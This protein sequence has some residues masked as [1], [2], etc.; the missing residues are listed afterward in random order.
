M[1]KSE[2]Q[3]FLYTI[4]GLVV[5]LVVF[6]G[7]IIAFSLKSQQAD[8]EVIEEGQ[9][10]K[11]DYD[12]RPFLDA[13]WSFS[14]YSE[15][16]TVGSGSHQEEI[17]P[18]IIYFK[19]Y[20][21]DVD[22]NRPIAEKYYQEAEWIHPGEEISFKHTFYDY[23]FDKGK[24]LA[25]LRVEL[26]IT[27]NNETDIVYDSVDFNLEVRGSATPSEI[28][29]IIIPTI[30]IGSILLVTYLLQNRLNKKMYETITFYNA[31]YF[32]F[33]F[34]KRKQQ[35]KKAANIQKPSN[36]LFFE[37]DFTATWEGSL[38]PSEFEKRYFP[39]MDGEPLDGS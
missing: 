22:N 16:K 32:I 15:A 12:P 36:D 31:W 30:G 8:F 25:K 23:L 3:N 21:Q 35:N 9:Y 27:K 33:K 19:F 34:F 18:F 17:Y 10:I 14:F 7:L 1:S 2:K 20:F 5:I 11:M 26:A 6:S 13:Q 4:I 29:T 39:E 37:Q 38:K 28:M 24:Y